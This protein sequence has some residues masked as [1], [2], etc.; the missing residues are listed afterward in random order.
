MICGILGRAMSGKNSFGEMLAESLYDS[1]GNVYILMAFAKNL[2]ERVQKDFDL[3]YDQ[4]WGDQKEVEDKRY[5]RWYQD[6]DDFKYWTPREILQEYGVFFR[7]ISSGFWVDSLFNLIEEKEYENVIITDVRFP[8][9]IEGIVKRGGINIEILREVAGSKINAEHISE[10]ALGEY[11]DLVD[12][13]INNNG[14]F[15]DLKDAA[16]DAVMAISAMKK[17]KE[18]MTNG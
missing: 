6:R 12:F 14:T 11:K 3:S 5:K 17:T 10:N 13:Y 7:T 18:I 1:T 9:E 4:L 16:N 8:N 15:D 2:K